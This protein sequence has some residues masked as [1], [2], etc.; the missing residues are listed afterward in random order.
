MTAPAIAPPTRSSR[1]PFGTYARLEILRSVRNVKFFAFSLGF[2]LIMFLVIAGPNRHEQLDGIAF[3]L[4]YMTGMASWGSMVA[5]IAGGARIAAERQIGWNRQLR[6]T[7]LDLR[8]YLATKVLSGYLMAALS[9]VLLYAAGMALGVRLSPAHWVTMTLMMLIGLI[10]F[11]ALGIFL[12]HTL[13]T[14]SMGPAM[15]GVTSLL[16][17][18]GGA[19][20]PV[21]SGGLLRQLSEVLPSYWLVQAGGTALV[22]ELWPAKG[23]IVLA[24]WTVV[25]A[26]L[27]ARAWQRDTQR[28]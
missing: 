19:W 12:G 4:Y 2:P 13:T 21:A 17:F 15:G 1:S 28:G 26:R 23:W 10:P 24:V 3:P 18:L 16:G 7:P 20:G 14:E 9:I 8:S 27:A 5:V 6:V 22:G 11:T 25:L